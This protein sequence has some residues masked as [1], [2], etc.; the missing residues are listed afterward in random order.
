[1]VYNKPE[2][3]TVEINDK[4]RICSGSNNP[5]KQGGNEDVVEEIINY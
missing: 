4:N 1:M 2:T 3:R 5:P